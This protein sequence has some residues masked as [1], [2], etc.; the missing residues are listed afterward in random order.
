MDSI[1]VR[2]KIEEDATDLPDDWRDD[3]E[4][5]PASFKKP[6]WAKKPPNKS[7]RNN[8]KRPNV[9]SV[10]RQLSVPATP[11]PTAQ[12]VAAAAPQPLILLK[13]A[14]VE[15]VQ[16]KKASLRRELSRYLRE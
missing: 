7:R 2:I 12:P 16:A 13:S 5:F 9:P 10:P 8:S 4:W 11:S 15:P 1:P 6:S 14:H 3:A